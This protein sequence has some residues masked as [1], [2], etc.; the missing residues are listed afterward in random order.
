MND[1]ELA[2]FPSLGPGIALRRPAGRGAFTLIE[3]LVV[4]AIIAILAALLLPA[5]SQAKEKAKAA[6]CMNNLKQIGL[7]TTMYAQDNN[8]TYFNLG[9]G[10][11]PNDGQWFLNPDSTVLLAPDHP[12]AYWALGYLD[13]FARNR[14]LFHCPDCVHPDEWHDDG[15]YYPNAFW[16]NS[17]YGVCQYL[18]KPYDPTVEPGLKKVTS[19]KDPSKMIFCQDSAEQRMEGSGGGGGDTIALFPGYTQILT[20]W[21]G[22]PPYGGLSTLYGSYH[23]ENEWYR[24]TK[25]C[26]TA[27]V[28]GHVSK[29]KFTGLKVGIDYRHY[30]GVVPL[31]PVPN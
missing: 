23:F 30:T 10:E 6:Q 15:R 7:A 16:Q 9:G 24:H 20:Q 29:I 8:D 19:Y 3:L 11:I 5:L 28:E 21:I 12:L 4:I 13:Y 25:G 31:N 26:Q 22:Q 17:T 14:T 27:W 1:V 2:G 18:L